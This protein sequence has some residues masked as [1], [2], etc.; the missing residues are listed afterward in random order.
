[1]GHPEPWNLTWMAIGNEVG[2]SHHS[3]KHLSVAVLMWNLT[4]M[5]SAARWVGG[6]AWTQ[7]S[8]LD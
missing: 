7:K 6:R 1:M 8:A 5:P 3:Q 2:G 4:R